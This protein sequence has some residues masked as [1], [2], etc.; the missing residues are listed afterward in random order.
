ML[1]L[2]CFGHLM[3]TDDSLE[4]FLILG[5]RAEGKRASEDEMAGWHHWWNEHE[6]GQTLRDGEGQGSLWCCK[7]S[8]TAGWMN[9]NNMSESS[10]RVLAWCPL[11][12]RLFLLKVSSCVCTLFLP[13]PVCP[14]W[15]PATTS[16]YYLVGSRQR[17]EKAMALHSSTHAW[18]IPWTEEPR[19]LQSIG[20]QRVGHDWAT[21]LSL[22]HFH[23]LEKEMATHSSVL[24][25]RIPGTGEPDGLLS[26]GSHRVGHDWSDLAAADRGKAGHVLLHILYFIFLSLHYLWPWV[27]SWLRW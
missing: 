10:S 15:V 13:S 23:A 4:K 11:G 3:W 27:L 26:M 6:L 7:E 20:S 9:S 19:G 16:T 12:T 8:D 5:K 14:I 17:Q 25:W 2:Q 1:K 24:A 18:K 22:F 21:S